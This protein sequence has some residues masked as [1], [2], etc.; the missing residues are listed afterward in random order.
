MPLISNCLPILLHF[1]FFIYDRKIICTRW[2]TFW[3]LKP[4]IKKLFK[5]VSFFPPQILQICKIVCGKQITTRLKL[6]FSVVEDSCVKTATKFAYRLWRTGS[7]NSFRIVFVGC[8]GLMREN[9]GKQVL[10]I[11]FLFFCFCSI[12]KKVWEMWRTFG[13]VISLFRRDAVEGGGELTIGIFW[14]NK[15]RRTWRIFPI[16]KWTTISM[17]RLKTTTIDY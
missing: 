9:R 12:K 4:K 10:N 13:L 8:W 7:M 11:C 3:H 6:F 5:K 16:T 2:T 14:E 1:L 15:K 17:R